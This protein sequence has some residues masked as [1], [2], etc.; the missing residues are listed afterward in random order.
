MVDLHEY[1]TEGVVDAQRVAE[2]ERAEREGE[3]VGPDAAEGVLSLLRLL[4]GH[5]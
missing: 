2:L 3:G 4:V 5:D 1:F